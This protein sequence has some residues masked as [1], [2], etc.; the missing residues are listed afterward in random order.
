[1][2]TYNTG[3]EAISTQTIGCH[4]Y[5]TVEEKQSQHKLLDIISTQ[6]WKRSSIHTNYWT[7]SV[8]NSGREA[9][10]T[11]TI[12]HHQ[13]TTVEEKQSQHKLLDIISTQQWKR[14]SLN[15]NYWTSSVH[16]SGREAVS[17]QTIGYHQYTTVE[18]KQYPHKL[19][20]IISIQQWKRSSI[21]INYWMSSVHNSGREAVSTQTIGH[22]QYTTVEEKQYPHKLLDIIS[23]Q[24]EEKQYPHK[25]LDI[26]STQQ[27]KRSSIHTNYWTSSVHNSGREAISTQTIGHH[28]YTSGRE[29]VS[30]QTIGHH[31]Y[32]TVEEKQYPHKLLDI[33]STQQWKRSSIHT[34]YWTSSVH[35][36]G[37][38]AISTQ[39]IGHHQYTSG[40]EAISTQTIGHHQYTTVEEKQYPHKLLDIISTQQW[41]LSSIHTNYWTSSVHN[42]G[43]EAISTQTIGHHQYTSG[44]EAVSTQTIGHHQYTTV[45]EKQY[46]HKLLD[47]IST[48]QWKRSSIHTNY[49]TSSVHNSGREAVSTQTIGHHQY[50]TVEEK[51]Y[52]HKLLDIISTQQWKRSSIH[53]N[54]WTSSVHNSGREAISTQTIGHHQYTNGREAVSTQNIGHHQYTTVEEK[55]YPHKL[56]DVISTQ[57]EEKQYPHKILDIISTQQ[58]KRSS[59]HTNYWT[60]SVHNSG[61]EAVSTQTIGHHQYTTVEEKQYPH[62]PLDIISTQQW[63]RSSIHT[64]YLTSSVHNS[65]RE[66]ISTNYWTS[67]VHKWKRS[68]IHT[69]YWTSSVHNS[70]REAISTQTI[71]HHQYTTVEEKQYPH[72]LLDIISIQQW[73]RSSIHTNYWTSSV[74]NSGREAISTQTIGHHQYTT[75][76]DK[77][78]PH[79]LLD[80]IST[81]Q[82]KRISIHTNYW[83]SSVHNSGR[84]AVSTQTI[85]CHQYTTVEE[86]QY[87]HKLLDV[88]ST[89]Q[90]KR[91]SLHTNYWTSS[92][93]NSGREAISTQTIGHHQYT[94]VE[95]KQYPHKLLDVIS[96]Q[97]WKRSSIHTNYWMSSVHN[98]G[99]EAV[100]TQTIGHHQYTT[101]EEKQYPHKL[102]DI[103]ST[104]VEEKQYPHKLLDIISTQQWKISNIHTNYLTS[105]VH[106]S[107]REAISTQTIGHHQY[108]SG[109]E[110]VSTQTIGHHQYTT[111]EEKQYP[112][113]LLD[114]I[115][116]QQWKI[117]NIHTNYWTSSVHNSGREAISTQ[118]IGHHQYTSGREAVSTQTIGHHQYTTVEEKQYPHKL[119]DIISTQ[120]WKRSSIHTNYWTSSVHNSGREAIST[121]TIGCHQYTTVEEK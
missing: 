37:R 16:N 121:Q 14:S 86:K 67:S 105:S 116:T 59:I 47:I 34:N 90:W 75:V 88:I 56:L 19:L 110:A 21:H 57:V 2:C 17:T 81:Q 41:K 9:V 27:W 3:R 92:V 95:E 113:K 46:P 98:S 108:T 61:R 119:L 42:S 85:G 107:G 82:W 102:L 111:V 13:Y 69:N 32:T 101:V 78:Y 22:H 4:Q 31:Q 10:S 68:S 77:Q 8:Y 89:Q 72:K 43:R 44:R 18:E 35:N 73:K 106:N 70:G 118:T 28:Q 96:T 52:P 76:E 114:I 103:I 58:W 120:Q 84:E 93:H 49:W 23:T 20:D 29:A 33:V 64:N 62:K 100:S 91:S 60:S 11:Q 87:P 38:E 12:G 66:A 36:N 65:G 7:S 115:S 51:Q 97:Q 6:Q 104:Q 109:R 25:L 15:I 71:G 53:T 24:V 39:T 5:T 40:R 99:R 80:V 50:T 79:K 30:T 26:I 94:T 55:Q 74:H 54:Y 1:M 63:K 45:E 112:H 83:M 48:Q 117:S